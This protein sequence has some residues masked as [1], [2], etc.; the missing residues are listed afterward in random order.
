[1]IKSFFVLSIL[2]LSPAILANAPAVKL[3]SFISAGSRTTAA[4]ACGK[5]SGITSLTIIK[6]TVDGNSSRPGTYNVVVDKD[7]P[8]CATVITNDGLVE[9]SINGIPASKINLE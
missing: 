2:L 1:M 8:F 3:T 5:A 6:L 9:A 7:G 4:E